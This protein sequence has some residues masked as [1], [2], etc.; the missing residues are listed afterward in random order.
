MN[1]ARHRRPLAALAAALVAASVMVG[2]NAGAATTTVT[3]KAKLAAGYR[4]LAVTK[5][6]KAYMGT[7]SK[8]SVTLTGMSKADTNAMTISVVSTSGAYVGPV[9]LK[10]MASAKTQATTISKAKSGFT[11]MKQVARAGTVNLGTVAVKGNYAYTNVKKP[12]VAVTGKAVAVSGGVPP[13]RENLG[14]TKVQGASVSAFADPV[15]NPAGG[16]ADGDGLPAF[17]DVDDD[18]DGR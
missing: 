1:P 12:V 5:A 4:M 17:V 18:N 16:D 3:I 11:A 2:T 13:A 6:G 7:S 15:D 10:Y 8:G 14:K 9:M